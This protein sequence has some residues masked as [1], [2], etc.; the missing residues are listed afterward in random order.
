MRKS[1]IV[2]LAMAAATV[3]AVALA[4]PAGAAVTRVIGLQIPDTGNV[5][6]ESSL[7]TY[8]MDGGLIGCWYTDAFDIREHSSGTV[9]LTGTE[10]FV[11]CLDQELDGSCVGNPTGT[12][13]F[14]F[15]FSG[16][17]DLITSA[18][19]RGRCQHLVVSG[20][21]DFETAGGVITFK[22]DVSTGIASYSGSVRL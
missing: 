11:G 17:F 7:G 3:I 6:P 18:E 1:S 4:A 5:C 8:T 10:H 16:R 14:A 21:D 20:T 9:Q 12:L 19:I 15:Q 13:R 22:D 2:L